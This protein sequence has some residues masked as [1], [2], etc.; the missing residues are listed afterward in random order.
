MKPFDWRG[1]DAPPSNSESGDIQLDHVTFRYGGVSNP[2]LDG[3]DLQVD[4]GEF[5][6][7]LGRSGSGK[8]TILRVLAGFERVEAGYVRIGGRLVGSSWVHHPP[9]RRRVG[10]VFQDYA[11]FP[12]L[13]V[14]GNVGFGVL[15]GYEHERRRRVDR[16]LE[17]AGLRDFEQR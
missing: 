6:S 15:S 14:A 12:H 7:I 16:V 1:S 9:D 17:M 10:L 8:T 5:V 11:L 13:T 3:I 2:V 4:S